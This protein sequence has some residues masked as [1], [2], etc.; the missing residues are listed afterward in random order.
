MEQRPVNWIYLADLIVSTSDVAPDKEELLLETFVSYLSWLERGGNILRD[1]HTFGWHGDV[2]RATASLAGPS[3]CGRKNVLA[4]AREDYKTLCEITGQSLNWKV[5]SKSKNQPPHIKQVPFIFIRTEL[6]A[7]GPSTCS[8]DTLDPIPGYRLKLSD[9]TRELIYHWEESYRRFDWIWPGGGTHA[10]AAY[11]ELATFD[12]D[13]NTIG[14]Q[15]R[16]RIEAESGL[17][18]YYFLQ[19]QFRYPDEREHKRRCPCCNSNWALTGA[20]RR[21]EIGFPEGAFDFCCKRCRLVSVAGS[22]DSGVRMARIGD[23]AGS[24]SSR[25]KRSKGSQQSAGKESGKTKRSEKSQQKP[26]TKK[27]RAKKS[28]SRRKQ[29]GPTKKESNT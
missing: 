26:R 12:S 25:R 11:R 4:W 23:A 5:V 6:N 24:D 28:S 21:A 17:P 18:T 14:Q 1:A 16:K 9:E 15:I 7:Q 27:A 13:V 20:A 10:T 2:L 29:T 8:G 22:I 3:A 19:R